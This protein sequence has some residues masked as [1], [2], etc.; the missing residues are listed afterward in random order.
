VSDQELAAFAGAEIT[1]A[2]PDGLTRL[3]GNGQC[4]GDSGAIVREHSHVIIV[5]YPFN[6]S[7]ANRRIEMLRTDYKL[8][9]RK[10]SVLRTET[11]EK[12]SFRFRLPN[13]GS[14]ALVRHC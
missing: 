13:K 10:E 12:V 9:F 11:V 3:D 2:F 14:S 7:G 8:K 4:R 6:D 5:R 1:P